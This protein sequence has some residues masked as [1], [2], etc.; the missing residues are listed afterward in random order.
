MAE[1]DSHQEPVKPAACTSNASVHFKAEKIFESYLWDRSLPGQAL[2]CSIH[3][4]IYIAMMGLCG[5][6]AKVKCN[7][8]SKTDTGQEFSDIWK[9]SSLFSSPSEEI[10]LSASCL[11]F[12]LFLPPFLFERDGSCQSLLWGKGHQ[13]LPKS[14]ALNPPKKRPRNMLIFFAKKWKKSQFSLFCTKP[15]K[16]DLLALTPWRSQA[17]YRGHQ[18]RACVSYKVIKN[19]VQFVHPPRLKDILLVHT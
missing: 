1:C 10:F 18:C 5:L 13:L 12:L 8:A 3:L 7:S 6:E 16:R 4:Y 17:K 14:C 15:P 11:Q 19:C 2:F 9:V